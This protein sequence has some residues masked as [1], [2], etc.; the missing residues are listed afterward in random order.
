[1]TQKLNWFSSLT[2]LEGGGEMKR[3][4][5]LKQTEVECKNPLQTCDNANGREWKLTIYLISLHI[6]TEWAKGDTLTHTI[7]LHGSG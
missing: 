3:R 4:N 1:M 5:Q 6:G 2:Q 7:L